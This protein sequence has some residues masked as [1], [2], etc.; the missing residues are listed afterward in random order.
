LHHLSV[1]EWQRET[2]TEALIALSLG[3]P[4]DELLPEE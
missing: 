2:E 1:E 3:F 4:I